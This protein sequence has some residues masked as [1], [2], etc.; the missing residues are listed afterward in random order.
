MNQI[1]PKEYYNTLRSLQSEA[2]RT[3]GNDVFRKIYNFLN[4]IKDYSFFTNL[5]D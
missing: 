3:K 1:L 5:K 2:L 4:K